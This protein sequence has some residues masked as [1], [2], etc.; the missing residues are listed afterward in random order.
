MKSDNQYLRQ[1]AINFGVEVPDEHKSSNWY[2][3]K[4][5]EA[6]ESENNE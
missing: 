4:I 5:K 6:L 1:I 2:L 3:K